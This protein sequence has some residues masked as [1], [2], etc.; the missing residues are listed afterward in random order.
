MCRSIVKLR[1]GSQPA[2]REE[3][4]AAA[5][6]YVRKISGFRRPAEHNAAVFEEA[7]AVIAEAS[8]RLLAGLEVRGAR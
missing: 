7:V 5:L 4:Q 3:I 2:P 8:E 6:Q 1:E